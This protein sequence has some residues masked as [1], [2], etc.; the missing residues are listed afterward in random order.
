[1]RE[2]ELVVF[3]AGGTRYGLDI[4]D[5]REIKK[6]PGR[7]VVRHAPAFVLGVV[8][9]R[10]RIVTLLDIGRIL[11]MEAPAPVFPLTALFL[12]DG[13]ELV[14]LAVDEVQDTVPADPGAVLP[15]PGNLPA[16]QRR[17]FRGI[18]AHGGGIVTL[19]DRGALLS[20][21]GM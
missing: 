1:M 11:G 14:G 13:D 21:E 19:L 17:F 20:S 8:N 15:L 5:V 6:V 12:P 3:R 7:T 16:A 4:R 10:G 18:I 9:L 2:T